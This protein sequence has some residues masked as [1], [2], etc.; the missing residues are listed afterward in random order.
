MLR[1]NIFN[2]S[3]VWISAMGSPIDRTHS[4]FSLYSGNFMLFQLYT[5]ETNLFRY[6]G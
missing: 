1:S 2:T 3:E 4:S 6:L 5:D